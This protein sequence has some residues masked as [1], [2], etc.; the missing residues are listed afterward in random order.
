VN[1]YTKLLSVAIGNI[2]VVTSNVTPL[3]TVRHG[4]TFQKNLNYSKAPQL[5]HRLDFDAG[6]SK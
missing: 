1:E 4:V 3:F 2:S 6:V 5:P